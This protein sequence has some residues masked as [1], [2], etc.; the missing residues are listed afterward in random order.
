[1]AELLPCGGWGG[2]LQGA[3]I[4]G[5]QVLAQKWLTSQHSHCLIEN[6][7]GGTHSH[8]GRCEGLF[9]CGPSGRGGFGKAG[10]SHSSWMLR[11]RDLG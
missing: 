11:T 3:G 7:S 5:F 9:R 4:P 2:A 1:M 6:R 10:S 8:T